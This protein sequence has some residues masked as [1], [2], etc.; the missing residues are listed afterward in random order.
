MQRALSIIAV[1]SVVLV[2][3][4]GTAIGSVSGQTASPMPGTAAEALSTDCTTAD[5]ADVMAVYM[6][7]SGPKT[8]PAIPANVA[9]YLAQNLRA[10]LATC[11]VAFGAG[12]PAEVSA[13]SPTQGEIDPRDLWT[14]LKTCE[15]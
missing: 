5:L 2:L 1:G 12:N 10:R 13:C 6:T 7:S 11:A 8:A 3:T 15:A 9:S 14:H 4:L